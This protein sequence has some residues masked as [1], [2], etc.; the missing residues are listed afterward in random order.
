MRSIELFGISMTVADTA[1]ALAE[2]MR[3]LK[4]SERTYIVTP[5]VDHVLRYQK[6]AKF[7]AVYAGAGLVL[8][9]GWPVVWASRLLGRPLP[10][11]VA[12]SDLLG[13]LCAAA[14]GSLTVFFLGGSKETPNKLT[15]R[16]QLKYPGLKI[17]GAYSPTP[18]EL[19]KEEGVARLIDLI[20]ASGADILF[21]G[22][23]SP[24]QEYFIY[25]NWAKL[26]VCLAI[27]VGIAL[28]YS[29]GVMPRAPVW[30]RKLG[31]EWLF[32]LLREP[33]RLFWRYF[34]ALILFPLLVIR[35]FIKNKKEK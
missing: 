34:K 17:A 27:G 30:L 6:D 26:K 8:A 19:D 9:D 3:R 4:I 31:L 10:E 15:E 16:F 18:Q 13:A 11:Q 2:I 35:E 33:K 28:D 25:D 20:N 32:R 22:L 12:G 24:K 7:R 5:N 21:V 14:A 29:A 1:S 23:G